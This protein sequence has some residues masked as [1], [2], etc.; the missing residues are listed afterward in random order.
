MSNI[1]NLSSITI[2]ILTFSHLA[3]AN[4]DSITDNLDEVKVIAELDNVKTHKVGEIK[5]SA[6]LLKKQQV[7]DSRDLVRYETG[8]SVV[9][10]G[11]FGSSG[12]AIQGVD[13]NRVAITVDGLHQAEILS[14]EGFKDLF[15]GYGNFN[16]TRN[17]VEIETLKQVQFAKGANSIKVGSGALGGAVIFETKDARDLLI[18]KNYHISYKKGYNTSDN[19]NIDSLTLAG[20]YKWFD[21]LLVKTKREGKELENYGYKNFDASVQ[22]RKREKADPYNKSLDSTL[23]K[24]AFQPNDNNRFTVA[25]DLYNNHSKGADLSYTLKSTRLTDFGNSREELEYRHNNDQIKRKNYAVSYENYSSNPLWDTLKVTYSEQSVK[26]RAKNEDYCDGNDKCEQVKNPLGLKYNDKNELVDSN[27][28]LVSYEFSDQK[29]PQVE[30]ITESEL[31]DWQSTYNPPQPIAKHGIKPEDMNP[32]YRC[33]KDSGAVNG[34]EQKCSITL[35][36]ADKKDN[37]IIDNHVYDLLKPENNGLV[38]KHPTNIPLSL[39]CKGINCNKSSIVGY[40]RNG[41]KVEIPFTVKD[42]IAE[43]NASGSALTSPYLFLPDSNGFNQNLWTERSLNTDTKQV[44][45]DLTKYLELGKTQHNL[46]YGALLSKT[47]KEMVNRSGDTPSNLKWWALYP[48]DCSASSSSLCNKSNTFSFLIPVKATNTAL[49][50]ADD[51]K[52]ND[53]FSFDLGYRYDRTK[54]QPQYVAGVTPKIPDD[55]VEGLAT[56]FVEPFKTKDVPVL[57]IEPS[58]P[59]T[60]QFT[61]Y[62]PVRKF[63]QVG[64]NAALEKYKEEK[65]KFDVLKAEKERIEQ[66]NAEIPKKNALARHQANVNVFA[67]DKKYSAQSYT[68]GSS[69][70]P[71]DYLRLQFKYAK[72]FRT[73]TSDEIYFTFKHPDFTVLPNLNLKE[74]TAKTQQASLTLHQD[75]GFITFGYFQTKYDNFIDLAYLGERVI[76]TGGAGGGISYPIHQNVNRD[77]AKVKG[78]ELTSRLNLGAINEKLNAFSLSYQMTYQKGKIRITEDG[79]LPN[80]TRSVL[81]PMNAIQPMKS[82]YGVSYQHQ[83]GKVGVDLY[84]IHTKAKEAKDTYNET[85]RNQKQNELAANDPAKYVTKDSTKRWRS[86]SYTVIDVIA[87]AKPIKNLTL[88]FGVYNLTNRKYITWDSARSIKQF[89]TSNRIDYF[90]GEGINRFTAPGRNY[91][92]NAEL[93]F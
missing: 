49:Y 68:F 64:Y 12:Y 26:T 56:D 47:K 31:N 82:I 32:P 19:Q 52:I 30:Y 57:P 74:E 84:V 6:K 11:R 41:S 53:Y 90:T 16:N 24:L 2:A 7:Q 81:V 17:G 46:S 62:Y 67:R 1:H 88:Q 69:I 34:N 85:W 75:Y 66:E 20:R 65:Q 10:N 73:P 14:S 35:Y 79:E 15:E 3:Y 44:N 38:R 43:L 89:G 9:E 18:D 91:R 25:A 45:L 86:N 80:S 77:Y 42:G 40:Q 21:L 76:Q 50:F 63:D 51:F 61:D 78:I 58:E 93:T 72:G 92:L 23:V 13:E 39:N 29:K 48:K 60:W 28:N 37:L 54:Y 8:I 4:T 55:M 71:T 59:A 36:L 87:Y 22:G 5:K 27:G 33:Y 70:D 83:S